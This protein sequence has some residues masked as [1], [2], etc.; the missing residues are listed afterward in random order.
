MQQ[1]TSEVTD[2]DVKINA[3]YIYKVSISSCWFNSKM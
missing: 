2:T 3:Y 1:I